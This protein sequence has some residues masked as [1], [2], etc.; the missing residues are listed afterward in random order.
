[1]YAFKSY[2]D[3]TMC[4]FK[5][6][7]CLNFFPKYSFTL[8]VLIQ[9]FKKKKCQRIEGLSHYSFFKC[10]NEVVSV[11]ARGVFYRF[12]EMGSSIFLINVWKKYVK[13][14][15]NVKR[16]REALP[17]KT[18]IRIEK[19]FSVNRRK[20]KLIIGFSILILA[21]H[22]VEKK[23]CSTKWKDYSMRPAKKIFN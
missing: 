14:N 9:P 3:C 1:M 20:L 13:C 19:T 16:Q 10:M 18:L 23:Y 12:F 11:C 5:E 8:K 22:L 17:L 15:D 7:V 21:K 4:L 2:L 6:L